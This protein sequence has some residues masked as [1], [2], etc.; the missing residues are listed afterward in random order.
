VFHWVTFPQGL[1]SLLQD[2]MQPHSNCGQ[3]CYRCTTVQMWLPV[4]EGGSVKKGKEEPLPIYTLLFAE[5]LLL[6]TL[7][8]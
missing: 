4:W 8:C 1:S 7:I 6:E 2:M 3:Q 5:H